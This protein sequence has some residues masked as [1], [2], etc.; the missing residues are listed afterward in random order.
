MTTS[1][2]NPLKITL[3]FAAILKPISID[4]FLAGNLRIRS[5]FARIS[6]ALFILLHLTQL[7]VAQSRSLKFE[8]LD[9][10]NGLSQN[11]VICAVQDSRGFLWFGTRDGVNRYDGYKFTI[12]RNIIGDKSSLSGN[13]IP[14]LAEDKEGNVWIGTTSEGLNK[15]DRKTDKFVRFTVEDPKNHISSNNLES[16]FTD[17]EGNIWIGSAEGTVDILDPRTGKLTSY[18]NTK[19]PLAQLQGP[20]RFIKEDNDFNIW[21][22]IHGS[23]MYKFE[24]ATQTFI[25]YGHDPADPKSIISNKIYSFF[26]DSKNRIWIG[27]DGYGLELFNAT[28]GTFKHFVHD[29]KNPTGISANSIYDIGEDL[30]GNVWFGTENGGLCILA[31]NSETFANYK[32]DDMDNSSLSNNSIYTTYCDRKGNMWIGTFSGGISLY[33]KEFNKFSHF[34]HTSSPNSLSNNNVLSFM[35]GN[36]KKIWIGTD[37]GGMDVFDPV[38]K[39]FTNYHHIAGNPNSIGGNYVLYSIT[40]SEGNIW[41]GT[42]A[43]GVSVYNP[44]AK[45][46]KHFKNDPADSTTLSNNNAWIIFEDSEKNMW[47]GMHEGGLDLFNRKTGRFTHF[48]V[49]DKNGSSLNSNIV[50][51]IEED[52]AGNLWIGTDGGGI[53]MYNKKTKRFSYFVMNPKKNSISNNSILSFLKDRKG[54]LWITTMMGV[55][56]FDTKTHHFTTYTTADGLPNNAVFGLIEDDENNLWISSNRGL[57][58]MNLTSKKITNYGL[59]DGLQSYE[60]KDHA[61]LKAQD[62]TIY[63]GGV[64]GFNVFKTSE[65]VNKPFDPPLV[66][67]SFQIFNRE[68]KVSPDSS[69]ITALTKPISETDEVFIDYS[70]SLV[71]FE[72]A[73]LNYTA[74][75]QKKYAYKLV[76]FDNTWN[77]IGN[78]RKATYTRLDPGSYTLKIRGVDNEG[79]WSTYIRELKIVIVPPFW[80]TTWFKLLVGATIIGIIVLLFNWRTRVVRKQKETLEQ[81]VQERTEALAFSMEGEKKSREEAERANKAKSIFLATMS[82]EIRTPMNGIIGMSSLL[83]QTSL[84]NE[85]LGYTETIQ[86]CGES[87][88][89]VIND[90]LDFSKIESGAMELESKEFHLRTCVEEVLDVF[91]SKA[92]QIGLDLIYQIDYSVPEQINGD[93]TRLRQVLINLISNAIKFTHSGEVFIKVYQQSAG[94]NGETT[95]CFEVRDTGIGIP[96]E[97]LGRLFKAFS[98][99]DS[100]TTR[101]YG[102]TGLGL[103]ICEKLIRL[104]GGDI[105]VSSEAGVGSTFAFTIK[106][107]AG[108]NTIPVYQV[109][110]KTVLRNKRVLVLD[111][112]ETNR[113][114]LRVQLE[115]WNMR[116]VLA[117]SGAEALELLKRDNT[118][119]LI[120]TDMHMPEMD[121]VEFSGLAKGQLPKLPILLLSSIGTEVGQENKDLFH[122]VLNKPVKQNILSTIILNTFEKT[123][124]TNTDVRPQQ[125]AFENLAAKYPLNIL[126]AED[127]LVN[128]QLA[129]IVLSKLGYSPALAENG[130]E[131]VEQMLAHN[132]DLIL[133]D[134]QM[135]EMDGHEATRFIRRQ[136]YAQPAII[137]MTA[138]AMQGDREQCLAA[139]MDDYISKP[140]K[141]EEIAAMLEKWAMKN[142]GVR[143]A[144]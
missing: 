90:I 57:S 44:K 97:K 84:N 103:V 95:I 14:S 122:A 48:M 121:G 29:P 70:N 1:T 93:S 82:H 129:L 133:M 139:G 102:G 125:I 65:I 5:A 18:P 68:V 130:R 15:Y 42:W 101:K 3:M 63:F 25:R 119:D 34:R 137:A 83:A 30:D 17:H 91:S 52:A 35:E 127:N 116:P 128:Q 96:K 11:N 71:S 87:L 43:E 55:N 100:S 132:F 2:V 40:D 124:L 46:W 86:T 16:L 73:S 140:V 110:D 38:T 105:T 85:Q 26:Q 13:Y 76:G 77:V 98:Q 7:S 126:I 64:N 32:R 81:Q 19:F 31:N 88:L 67:T 27:T 109:T 89:T 113:T 120:I 115:H 6:V 61:F 50:H 41:I 39:N 72:F 4:N 49:N 79:E 136:N 33:N 23:G 62:G 118:F 36:D 78:Q 142:K 51:A 134:V 60:F 112:N 131:A 108:K 47:V 9:I 66:L 22:G 94:F 20:V 74:W 37:G 75:E 135:P 10:N 107:S 80:L 92:A 143:I 99:V 58:K 138:N 106:S 12:Y 104:M 8:R 114:I 69:D 53:N 111:D 59:A 28:T 144:S 117:A 45:T 21:V 141:P 54:N 123:G 24:R 56:Y